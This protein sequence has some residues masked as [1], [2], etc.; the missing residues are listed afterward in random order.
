[1]LAFPPARMMAALTFAT[2]LL[3]G[4]LMPQ[5]AFASVPPARTAADPLVAEMLTKV[6]RW[7]MYTIDYDLQNISQP[8]RAIA[9]TRNV[10][11]TDFIVNHLTVLG[12]QIEKHAFTYQGLTRH[13]I[14]GT[15]PGT[16][17]TS[18]EIY[19]TGGH[20]DS[21]PNSPGANDDGTG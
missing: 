10:K 16:D 8:D 3:L 1:M 6:N 4:F 12:L 13:N 2:L 17:N 11:A 19:A 5:S 7:T 14:V 21:V 20:M 15:L 9:S 18:K